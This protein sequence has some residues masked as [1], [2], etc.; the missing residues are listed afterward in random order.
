LRRNELWN[1]R[2]DWIDW[3]RD[4]IRIKQRGEFE[5]KSHEEREIP[6]TD[7]LRAHLAGLPGPRVGPLLPPPPGMSEWKPG[8]I[9][10][11]FYIRTIAP[12]IKKAGLE[13]FTLHDLRHSFASRLV[14]KGADLYTVA[15]LLG[16]KDVKTTQIY[17]HLAPEHLKSAIR[18]LDRSGPGEL[19]ETPDGRGK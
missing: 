7:R 10:G 18:L 17:S 19:P 15:K 9:P 13:P 11:Y 8:S 16:H 12:L 3:S 4:V 6:M 1:L 5:T 2:W 14:Q